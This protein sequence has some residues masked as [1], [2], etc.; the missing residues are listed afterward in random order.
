V[1]DLVQN[2][3]VKIDIIGKVVHEKSSKIIIDGETKDF[4]PQFRESAYT[5]IKK[6]VGEDTPN[7]FSAMKEAVDI[8][9]KEASNKK[10]KVVKKLKDEIV[11]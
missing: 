2:A 3:G 10:R 5:P 7:N 11:F 8:A 6:A 9:A 1:I 4:T